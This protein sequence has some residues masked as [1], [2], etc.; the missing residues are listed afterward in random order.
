MGGDD[1]GGKLA[2]AKRQWKESKMII[3]LDRSHVDSAYLNQASIVFNEQILT[4]IVLAY[5]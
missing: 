2:V 5:T 1:L 3:Y 4:G